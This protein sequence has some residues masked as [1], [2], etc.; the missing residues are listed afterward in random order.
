MC[1]TQIHGQWQTATHVLCLCS[2]SIWFMLILKKLVDSRHAPIA[3]H[4]WS[5]PTPHLVSKHKELYQTVEAEK[6][7]WKLE[8]VTTS[9]LR[10]PRTTTSTLTQSMINFAISMCGQHKIHG[11]FHIAALY[12]RNDSVRQ[13]AILLCG[14]NWL[15]KSFGKTCA[16]ISSARARYSQEVGTVVLRQHQ[17]FNVANIKDSLAVLFTADI[18][19]NRCTTPFMGEWTANAIQHEVVVCKSCCSRCGNRSPK[20]PQRCIAQIAQCS[21]SVSCCQSCTS[22][23]S[24]LHDQACPLSPATLNKLVFGKSRPEEVGTR[25]ILPLVLY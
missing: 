20:I 7:K 19:T 2:A 13:F 11:L 23:T 18:W 6:Q 3:Q 21:P 25:L 9:S 15:W 10:A 24:L 17:D 5:Q 8:A 16:T 14:G 12:C 4:C 1:K 22:G